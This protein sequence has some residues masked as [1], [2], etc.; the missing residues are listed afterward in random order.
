MQ[1]FNL[2]CTHMS[3]LAWVLK[4]GELAQLERNTPNVITQAITVITNCAKSPETFIDWKRNLT[5]APIKVSACQG[6]SSINE[7]K[8]H[9]IPL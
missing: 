7:G 1:G 9:P 6:K 8:F 4:R 5:W 2:L 3:R